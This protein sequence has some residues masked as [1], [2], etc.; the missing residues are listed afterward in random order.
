MKIGNI[1]LKNDLILAPIAGYSDLGMR[2]LCKRYGAALTFTEMVSA[3]GL[4][5]GNDNTKDLLETSDEE[6]IKGVQIFGSEP[7]IIAYAIRMEE[8]KKFDVIDINMGCPVPK[9]VKNGE[10][11]ALMKNPQ[12]VYKIIKAA[13]DAAEGKSVTAKIRAGFDNNNK[14]AVEIAKAIEEGGASAI[15]VHG[16][17]REMYYSGATDLEI[18]KKVKENV[19]IPVIGNG[20]IKDRKSYLQMKDFCNVDGVMLARGSIGK[21]YVFSEILG[22]EYNFEIKEI[23]KEHINLLHHLK[24]KVVINNMKKQIVY[25]IKGKRNSK[26]ILQEVFRANTKKEFFEAI[27]SLE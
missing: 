25:Y 13:T 16:R 23:I 12:L 24:E 14:N 3:K 1:E 19:S 6:D 10:G 22:N 9:I 21:P 8:L 27:S 20:D 5:Y 4:F 11:S 26:K 2:V 7:K 15:T 17:T 18:I